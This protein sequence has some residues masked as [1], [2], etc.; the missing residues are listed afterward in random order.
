VLWICGL[1]GTVGALGEYLLPTTVE[2]MAPVADCATADE[3]PPAWSMRVIENERSLYHLT[4]QKV[5]VCRSAH[6][7]PG[8]AHRFAGRYKDQSGQK[9]NPLVDDCCASQFGQHVIM[10]VGNYEGNGSVVVKAALIRSR[11]D[12]LKLKFDASGNFWTRRWLRSA[13]NIIFRR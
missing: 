9:W 3:T 5:V 4:I 12:Y 11:S 6:R 2:G 1:F 8:L 7:I 13:S 10:M